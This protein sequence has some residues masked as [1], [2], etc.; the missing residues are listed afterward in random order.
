LGPNG[1]VGFGNIQE[2]GHG[3]SLLAEVLFDVGLQ[4]GYVV[5][6]AAAPPEERNLTMIKNEETYKGDYC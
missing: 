3:R 6:G 5:R 2:Y 1:V 4:L